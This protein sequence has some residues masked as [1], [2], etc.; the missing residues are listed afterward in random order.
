[1]RVDII[2]R[3]MQRCWR[4]RT[5]APATC[6]ALAQVFDIGAVSAAATRPAVCVTAFARWMFTPA[7]LILHSQHQ[8][9]GLLIC[10]EQLTHCQQCTARRLLPDHRGGHRQQHQVELREP[11]RQRQHVDHAFVARPGA[12]EQPDAGETNECAHF[13]VCVSDKRLDGAHCRLPNGTWHLRC[14]SAA[15]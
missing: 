4:W 3:S 11:T 6:S 15:H 10:I 1:L 13:S 7:A 5:T 14:A 9:D 8:N 2:V 12:A